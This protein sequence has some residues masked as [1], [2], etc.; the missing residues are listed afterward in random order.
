M[1]AI[2]VGCCFLLA[3]FVMRHSTWLVPKAVR[4]RAIDKAL[5]WCI[6]RRNGID[7][8]GGIF[9]AMVN[10][11]IAMDILGFDKESPIYRETRQA[12]DNLLVRGDSA[13]GSYCQPCVSPI[14]DSG[15]SLLT[16]AEVSENAGS[17]KQL[18]KCLSWFGQREVREERGDWRLQRPQLAAGGWA[19]QYKNDYYPDVDDTAVVGIA[20]DKIGGASDEASIERAE[21]WIVGMQ[22]KNGGW[23]AFDADNTHRYLDDIPFADHG[24]LRDPPTADVTARC[25]GFLAQRGYRRD[26]DVIKRGLAYLYQQQEKDGSW[27]GRWGTNYIYGTWSVL[28]ALRALG[29]EKNINAS[30]AGRHLARNMP[31]A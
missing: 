13:Q 20:L 16:L 2:G 7:G 25:L 22:S 3:D 15:L 18:Q 6:Q 14:W 27:F 31:A 26:H 28:S 4:Q 29:E 11:L 12:I 9:P 1:P 5:A 30:A 23:G 10:F 17:D 21:R 24:A 19:F 8:L